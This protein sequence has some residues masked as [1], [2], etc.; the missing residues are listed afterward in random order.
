VAYVLEA[1]PQGAAANYGFV[2]LE[3]RLD[4]GILYPSH[5]GEMFTPL[6]LFDTPTLSPTG[7]VMSS[8]TYPDTV[9]ER[10]GSGL[11]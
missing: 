3:W 8:Y 7:V 9:K 10:K 1:T 6:K 4:Q 11:V 5:K 2:W